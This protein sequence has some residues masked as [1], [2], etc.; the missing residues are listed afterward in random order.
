MSQVTGKTTVET[1]HAVT[2]EDVK[3]E[4]INL[5]PQKAVTTLGTKYTKQQIEEIVNYYAT[6]YDVDADKMINTIKCESQFHNVQSNIVKNGIREDS[7]GIVQINMYY[8][9]TVSKEQALDPHFA[10]EWMAKE[11]KANHQSKWT[12]YRNI[13]LTKN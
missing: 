7:W 1:A 9:P 10:I 5:A 6:I 8:N 13:Y 3:T 12:C 11:F 2:V 4:V